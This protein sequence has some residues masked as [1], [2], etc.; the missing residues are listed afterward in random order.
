MS[1]KKTRDEIG[2]AIRHLVDYAA[3]TEPWTSREC[4]LF[5]ELFA[6]VAEAL[7][8]DLNDVVA[9]VLEGPHAEMAFAFAFEETATVHWN[10]E[11]KSLVDVYLAARGWREKP[12]GRRY[13]QALNTSEIALWEVVA[14]ESGR[15]VDIRPYGVDG[16]T[17]RVQEQSGSE[18][19]HVYDAL[20]TR[21]I[22]VGG[23]RMFAGAVLSY[24]PESARR[25]EQALENVPNE[26]RGIYDIM[27]ADGEIDSVPKDLDEEIADELDRRLPGVLFTEWAMSV[28][29][30][31]AVPLEIA[32]TDAEAVM[33]TRVRF[34]I[35]ASHNEITATL[36]DLATLVPNDHPT[37]T[38]LAPA[39]DDDVTR[40]RTVL[41]ILTLDDTHLE[42]ATN[43]AER[44]RR[45]REVLCDNARGTHRRRTCRARH[46]QRGSGRHASDRVLAR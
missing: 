27:L 36:S 7:G 2:A 20:A 44:A 26:I 42:L 37:W 17:V 38:W 30:A 34:P 39:D 46:R 23:T 31:Y 43:S 21:V 3:K 5:D 11:G 4:E 45:G 28:L 6:P 25:V 24:S 19:V 41:G 15:S 29:G 35:K 16:K 18:S 9:A 8:R 22:T 33:P 1:G 14:V 13:L 40:E 12:G 32:N 10:N